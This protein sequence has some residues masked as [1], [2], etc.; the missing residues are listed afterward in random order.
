MKEKRKFQMG[1]RIF[2]SKYPDF[3]SKDNDTLYVMTGWDVKATVLNFH[4]DG[5]DC[6]FIKDAPKEVL[7][8]ETLESKTF[9]RAGK[10]LVPEFVE[11]IGMTIDD[12]KQLAPM[13]DKMD[14]G[15]S[16]EKLIYGYYVENGSF[17]LTD[18]Q[19]LAA[20]EDYKKTRN[21]K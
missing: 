1:S 18:K 15:H 11:Y 17:T 6:F 13:F 14:E 4:K 9:M 8:K 10:F 21:K 19:R 16:Y 3:E 5:R 7:I 2:F 12:L 20:Y